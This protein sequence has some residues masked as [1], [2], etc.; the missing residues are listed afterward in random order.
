VFRAKGG[1]VGA[2]TAMAGKGGTMNESAVPVRVPRETMVGIGESKAELARGM[3]WVGGKV[4]GKAVKA[5][6]G[7]EGRIRAS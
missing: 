4:V 2:V 7:R 6:S 3:K 1:N 5:R